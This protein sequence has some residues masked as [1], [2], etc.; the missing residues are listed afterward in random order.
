MRY[1]TSFIFSLFLLGCIAGGSPGEKAFLSSILSE[2]I[3][4][5]IVP[6]ISSSPQ[7][8]SV[9]TELNSLKIYFPYPLVKAITKTNITLDGD[10]KGSLSISNFSMQNAKEGAIEFNGVPIDGEV[11]FQISDVL[12]QGK[13]GEE[14]VSYNL[15]YVINKT[16]PTVSLNFVDGDF[17]SFIDDGF[18][19][20]NFS[21]EVSGALKIEN[22]TF[23]EPL[24]SDVTIINVLSLGVNNYR[25][26]LSGKPYRSFT[27][28]TLTLSGIKDLANES[29]TKTSFTY[30]QPTFKTVGNFI[31]ARCYP[32]LVK[33]ANGKILMI[34][35]MD[36]SSNPLSSIE[37]FDPTTN[38][39]S[40]YP[41]NMN[42][43]RSD[44]TANLLP[45]GKIIVVAGRKTSSLY[46]SDYE[47]LDP[48]GISSPTT[49]SLP[50]QVRYGHRAV[51]AEDGYLYVLGGRG[52]APAANPLAY[53]PRV[54]RY[55]VTTNAFENV[56]DMASGR[57]GLAAGLDAS[58]KVIVSGGI[59]SQS[60][61][62]NTFEIY[63]PLLATGVNSS[64]TLFNTR[65]NHSMLRGPSGEQ[66]ILGGGN[67]D[68]ITAIEKI[69]NSGSVSVLGNFTEQR[70]FGGFS[71]WNQNSILA[72]GGSTDGGLAYSVESLNISNSKIYT[73]GSLPFRGSCTTVFPISN[74]DLL[75]LTGDNP[76]QRLKLNE[77]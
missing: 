7:N 41:Y 56:R 64:T 32:Q 54:D 61:H 47:L 44:F 29:L 73:I 17:P 66:Y 28:F 68:K 9:V 30:F 23:S 6:S 65:R 38:V 74:T 5:N 45:N 3:G 57:D 34:G 76:I 69:S 24:A 62:A 35:G 51:L 55:N 25:L 27:S 39:I 60:F 40:A 26:V 19:D 46:L 50:A 36:T 4:I 49:G 37:I 13:F 12:I 72:I 52:V 59:L 71:F 14:T 1:L 67:L 2:V 33:N 11:R 43:P 63:D 18:L 21:E 10:G 58:G 75:I 20:L 77:Q 15:R 42:Q 22:Y 70:Y 8:S 48:D 16:R 53:L 31:T